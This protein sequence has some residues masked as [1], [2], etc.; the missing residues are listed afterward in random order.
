MLPATTL[1]WPYDPT[2]R[3]GRP[4]D[5]VSSRGSP[6]RPYGTGGHRGSGAVPGITAATELA[7]C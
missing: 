1:V 5:V 2:W 4:H 3:E 7:P 6:V